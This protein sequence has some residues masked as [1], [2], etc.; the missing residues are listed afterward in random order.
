MRTGRPARACAAVVTGASSGIGLACALRLDESGFR[1]FAGVRRV[2]DDAALRR[3]G[4]DRLTPVFLDVTDPASIMSAVRIVTDSTGEIGLSALV[5]NAG[6]VVAGSLEFLPV[7]EIR[8]Q[9]EVNVLG[10][11]AVTQAFLPLLRKG[12]G[13]IVNIGSVGGRIAMPFIG[14]YNASKFAMEAFTDSLR[15]EL[16]PWNIPVSIIEPTFIDTPIWE[17]S[18]ARAD[19][20]LEILPPEAGDLYGPIFARVRE[21]YSRAGKPR[22][23]ANEVAKIVVHVLTVRRPKAR[24]VIGKGGMMQTVV[25]A[26]L[27]HRLRD[28]LIATFLLRG[29][30]GTPPV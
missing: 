10:Q 23:P 1:V 15:L 16:R 24:Y 6:I 28:F 26:H 2:E 29:P 30:K 14:P 4:S 7:K 18:L 5:N 22:T 3:L 25:F 8:E 12:Q 11:I 27:P 17:K 13:R 9:F 21:I 20:I 19:K